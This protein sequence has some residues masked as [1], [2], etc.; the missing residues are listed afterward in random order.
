M[1][2]KRRDVPEGQEE[3]ME[4]KGI[5][6][7]RAQV[8]GAISRGIDNITCAGFQQHLDCLCVSC[9]RGPM[10]GRAAVDRF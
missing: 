2:C 7:K 8:Q 9:G 1:C 3:I 4:I 6:S 5:K 10:Q